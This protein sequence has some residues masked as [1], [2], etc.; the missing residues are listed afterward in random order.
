[1]KQKVKRSILYVISV[2]PSTLNAFYSDL[3]RWLLYSIKDNRANKQHQQARLLLNLHALEKGLSFKVIKKGFGKDKAMILYNLTDKYVKKYSVDEISL[4]ALGVLN[5][6]VKHPDAGVSETLRKGL[7]RI[8]NENNLSE[9]GMFGGVKPVEKLINLDF[10]TSYDDLYKIAASRSSV[11]HYSKEH[12]TEEEIIQAVRYAQTA[13]SV[14]NRQA[15]RVHVFG[16]DLDL[17]LATQLGNQGWADKAD[18]LFVVTTDLNFFGSVY[19]RNQAFIDG[20]MFAM[21]FVM[22]LHAQK[23]ASCCKMY[24]R[25]PDLD[26]KF[27][28]VTNIPANEIPIML[29]LAGHY[30]VDQVNVPYSYRYRVENALLIHKDFDIL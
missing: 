15:S 13:P 26:K 8:C 30:D 21:Q 17:I 14:C 28:K 22:G 4:L 2:L 25:R 24:I 27:Y 5:A 12:I 7:I 6:F 9:V 10:N 29:I 16:K 1:M 18:K 11:R 19:E 23:I 20:G 3:R